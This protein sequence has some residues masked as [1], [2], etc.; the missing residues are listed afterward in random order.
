MG[1][2]AAEALARVM[3]LRPKFGPLFPLEG[4]PPRTV[5]GVVL[6]SVKA[7]RADSQDVRRAASDRVAFKVL[8]LG[9]S[10]MYGVGQRKEDT[11]LEQAQRILARRSSR[12]VEVLNLAI[13]GY[14]T[15]QESLVYKELGDQIR[16]DL[17]LVHFWQDDERQYRVVGGYVFDPEDISEDGRLLVRA[18]P[19]PDRV[20]DFLLMHSRLYDLLTQVVF[21]HR[22]TATRDDAAEWARV[23]EALADIQD[24]VR[25]AGGRMLVLAS[26]SLSGTSPR[27]NDFLTP[28]RQ[29]ASAHGIEV[30]DLSEWL[31]GVDV[32]DIAMDSCHFNAAG[33]HVIGER[34]AEYL[35][36][37]DLKPGSG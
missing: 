18:L 35:L 19:V 16:P 36:E 13:P 21:A 9:D 8:G 6:W 11:Y 5:D 4:T 29:F 17:V 28:L 12:P 23:C 7:P 31:R 33:H 2:L 15:I 34:L 24:R 37:H 32:R 30:I 1:L 22:R 14:N 25:R 3:G 27:P 10:I 26:P 20:N